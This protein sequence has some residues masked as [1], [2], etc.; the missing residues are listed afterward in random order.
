MENHNAQ[1]TMA[2]FETCAPKVL[3]NTIK[4]VFLNKDGARPADFLGHVQDYRVMYGW[5][6][7][8]ES[9]PSTNSVFNGHVNVT[10]DAMELPNFVA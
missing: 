7:S 3:V 2:R 8:H 4:L 6:F 1:C 10:E 9:H 5:V